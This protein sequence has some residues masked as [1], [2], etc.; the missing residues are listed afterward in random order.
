MELIK[1]IAVTAVI[2]LGVGSLV[3]Y[4]IR[5]KKSGKPLDLS[6]FLEEIID[7]FSSVLS[8]LQTNRSEYSSEEEFRSAVI[9]KVIEEV[10]E[11]ITGSVNKIDFADSLFEDQL[12]KYCEKVYNEYQ[13]IIEIEANKIALENED[14]EST[15]NLLDVEETIE[16]KNKTDISNEL[17]N[18]YN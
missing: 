5:S 11:L 13:D 14:E 12:R 7:C 17:N 18:F 3:L 15:D 1:I 6:I 9:N 10:K 4:Y 2:I 16:Q 8:I